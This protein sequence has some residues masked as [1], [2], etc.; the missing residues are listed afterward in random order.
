MEE[1]VLAVGEEA[2]DP[3]M[4]EGPRQEIAVADD[5]SLAAAGQP[6]EYTGGLITT[7]QPQWVNRNETTAVGHTDARMV[8]P[9]LSSKAEERTGSHR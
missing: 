2:R 7:A 9:A 8:R 4:P 3:P 5:G 1:A 6:L